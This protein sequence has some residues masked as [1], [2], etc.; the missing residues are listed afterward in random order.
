MHTQPVA[1]IG[2]RHA[3]GGGAGL[4]LG[5]DAP[6]A[7]GKPGGSQPPFT[8]IH[9]GPGITVWHVAADGPVA[10][11]GWTGAG[12]GKRP[13]GIQ[14]PFTHTHPEA[15]DGIRHREPLGTGGGGAVTLV[16]VTKLDTICCR[17]WSAI[18]F[19]TILQK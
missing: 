14:P 4:E 1:G 18:V 17:S 11:A 16:P 12:A 7:S 19:A 6:L 15:G 8:Q 13:G 3:L 9:P 10:G 2:V 5:L